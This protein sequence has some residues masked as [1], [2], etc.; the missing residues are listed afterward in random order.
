MIKNLA[1]LF[2]VTKLSAFCPDGQIRYN[3][4]RKLKSR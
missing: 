4:F 3:K 2:G 1:E